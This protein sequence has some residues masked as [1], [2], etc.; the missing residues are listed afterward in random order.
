MK[1]DSEVIRESLKQPERFSEIFERHGPSVGSFVASR[2][3]I[4]GADDALSETFLSAFRH[5]AKFRLESASARPWLMGIAVRVMRRH[6]SKEAAFWRA[7]A[8]AVH[9]GQVV[10]DDAAQDVSNRLDA[11]AAVREISPL[12]AALSPRDRDVLFL[13]AWGELTYQQ[14]A[15]A[16][17]MPVGTVASRLNRIRLRLAS[18]PIS[19]RPDPTDRHIER[20][21]ANGLA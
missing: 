14:I 11:A 20:T 9:A 13:Y 15:D 4:H 3:G 7:S 5:R 19:A 1:T 2:L 10:A 21:T 18:P 6:R 12:I 8:Q 17:R 16:L